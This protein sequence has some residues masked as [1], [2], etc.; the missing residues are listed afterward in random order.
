MAEEVDQEV[1]DNFMAFHLA[2]L[3]DFSFMKR[4]RCIDDLKDRLKV[5]AENGRSDE[6]EDCPKHRQVKM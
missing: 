4:I 5:F 1:F 6:N 3:P 2:G